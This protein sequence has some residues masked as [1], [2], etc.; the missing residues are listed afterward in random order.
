M[1]CALMFT[2]RN[3]DGIKCHCNLFQLEQFNVMFKV[4]SDLMTHWYE[5]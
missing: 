3:H 1:N 2:K 5:M 4:I